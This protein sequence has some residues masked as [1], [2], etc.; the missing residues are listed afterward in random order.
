MQGKQVIAQQ[1]PNSILLP[2]GGSYYG[3]DVAQLFGTKEDVSNGTAHT[4][5]EVT[6]SAYMMHAFAAFAAIIKTCMVQI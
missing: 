1:W 3:S 4:E 2:G 5:T 6:F